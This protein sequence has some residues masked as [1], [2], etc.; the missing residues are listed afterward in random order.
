MQARFAVRR[1][2][3]HQQPSGLA[4]YANRFIDYKVSVTQDRPQVT[5]LFRDHYSIQVVSC[6]EADPLWSQHLPHCFF[7]AKA[8]NL[9]VDIKSDIVQNV[10][11][12][13]LV[14]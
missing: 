2:D 9:F 5:M 11:S 7:K 3:F 8:D 4:L 12:D 6:N 10:F 13:L 14:V 1:T